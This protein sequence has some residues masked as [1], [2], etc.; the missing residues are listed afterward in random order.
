MYMHASGEQLAQ[1]AKL[2]DEGKLR[3]PI[4]R[5]FPLDQTQA[6]LDYVEAGKAHGKVIVLPQS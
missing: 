3:A 5:E 4:D 6:A 2:V 1:I